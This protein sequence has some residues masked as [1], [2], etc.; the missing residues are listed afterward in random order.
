MEIETLVRKA[1]KLATKYKVKYYEVRIA[2]V[3]ATHIEIQNSHFE[4]ISSNME[5]GI[6]V[7]VFDGSWGFSSANDLRRAEKAL[8]AAMKIAKTSKGNSKI[9]LGDPLTDEAE[10]KVKKSFLDVD[11]EEKIELLKTLD[12]LL[13]GDHIPNRKITY[14]DGIKEQFYFN[15]LGSEIK[16]IVPKIRLSFSVT[17]KEND[18]MQT[19]WKVFGGTTGWESIEDID[20]EYWASFVKNKATSLLQAKLP[21]SGEFDIIMDPELTGVF[22]H[23][24]LGHAAE[25]DAIKNGESIL[26]GKLGQNIAV[27]ELTVVDDPTLKK[28]FGSYIYDDEGIKA[29]K[30]EII[31]D[32]VL[33]EYL[34]DRE[35][36]AFFGTESNGHGRAQSYNYQPL[37]RMSNTYIEPR[38]WNFE[39]M[40]EEVKNG[41]Y[42]IGDKGGQV[43]IAN[44][45]FMFGAKEG[46]LIENGKIKYHIRD[47][48][49]SGK[50]LD[51]LKNIR[52]IGKDLKVNFPG[53]CGKGQW[54]SVDDGGPHILT[55]ALVGGL[56]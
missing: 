10:I 19:Y 16:T 55:R 34:L 24:A 15:S 7:R 45:T 53:Y 25:G 26:E 4:D 35:T 54:V 20:L 52:G 36:A 43:D 6:G 38:D 40:I 11:L 27:D 47:V 33:N 28:K 13:K 29:R 50:I 9:Y 12:S 51:I 8:E 5:I 21:P 32:G 42:L 14:G 39:E 31:K 18:D 41:L 48:A 49:L 2:R 1:E 22:I 17:A 3:N 30:V 56:L 46:Y 44:G 23:E 37:V